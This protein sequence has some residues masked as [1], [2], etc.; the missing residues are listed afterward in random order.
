MNCLSCKSKSCRRTDSCGAESFG[1]A[2]SLENYHRPENQ[3]VIGAAA[4]LVDGGRAGTLSRIQEI[5]EF[6]RD[7]GYHNIGIAYCYGME[8]TA[9][10][11]RDI[12]ISRGLKT[13]GVSCT[14]GGLRQDQVNTESS[15]PGVSCS[16]LNQAAQLH[17]QNVDLAVVIGLCL[18]HDILFNREFD[19]DITTLVVKDRTNGHNPMQGIT[20][21]SPETSS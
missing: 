15:L 13:T 2:E 6:A 21:F 3:K 8:D 14:V 1:L 9:L 20:S 5:V 11:V 7:M 19:G 18:G 17:A 10:A 12:F 16:P 4:R